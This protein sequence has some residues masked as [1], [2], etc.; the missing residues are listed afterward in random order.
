MV[1]G[2]YVNKGR[3][4]NNTSTELLEQGEGYV[5]WCDVFGNEDGTEDTYG[6]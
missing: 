1:R 4:N 3:R 2:T 6:Q 5:A